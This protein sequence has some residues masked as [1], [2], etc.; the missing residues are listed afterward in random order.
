M[1]RKPRL[2]PTRNHKY[3]LILCD[4]HE[5]I[6][7]HDFRHRNDANKIVDKILSELNMKRIEQITGKRFLEE[8]KGKVNG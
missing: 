2:K 3:R 7:T 1:K 8:E 6:I 5:N 4:Q